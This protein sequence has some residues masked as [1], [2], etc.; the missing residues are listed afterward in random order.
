MLNKFVKL[1]IFK[2][3][4]VYIIAMIRMIQSSNSSHAKSYF[5]DSLQKAD[6]YISDQ[7]QELQGR[8]HGK[9]SERIGLDPVATKDSFFAFCENVNP[10]TGEPLTARTRDDRTIGYDINFHCPKSVSILHVLSKDNHIM[11]AFQKS[12]HETMKHIEADSMTRVRK[13]GTQE[14]RKTGELVYAEFTHQ[15]ARPVEGFAPDPHLHSHCFTFNA[16]WDEEEKQIKAC[17]FRDI[18]RDMPY[19]Q[20]RFHKILS[21][22]LIDLGYEIRR[23][24]KSFEVKGI[25]KGVIGLFS[26][27]TDEIGQLAKEHG[28]T[29]PKQLDELGARTRSSKQKGLSM[30]ELKTEWRRQINELAEY[31]DGEQDGI[32]R[33][34]PEKLVSNIAVKDCVDHAVK[35][36]F[37]RASVMR[38]RRI[39]ETAYRHS[40]GARNIGLNDITDKFLADDEIIHVQE[41]HQTLCTTK[42]VLKEE[43]HMVD[44]ARQGKGKFN[45]IYANEPEI[46]LDGQLKNAAIHVLT[47]KDQVT[48]VKGGAGTGKTTL[49]NEIVPLLKK[50][51]MAPIIVAPSANASRGVL[52]EEGH[53]NA[54]TVSKLLVDKK[55]QEALKN[56]TLIVDEAGLL[57][58]KQATALLRLAIEKNARLIFLGDTRQHS[59]VER[60]DALRIINTVGGIQT[61]EVSKIHRQKKAE[62]KAAVQDL[63]EGNVKGAF[64][65]LNNIGA[66]KTI[67]PLKPNTELVDD[68]IKTVKK[69]KTA[70]IVSPTNKQGQA[71]TEDVRLRL[72]AER[73]IGKKELKALKLT[74]A[75]FTDAEKT[76][77]RNFEKG[78]IVKFDQNV[79]LIK[80]GSTW[81]VKDVNDKGVIL[82]DGNDNDRALPLNRATAFNVYKPSEIGLSK[83][84]KVRVNKNGFD[85][86]DKRMDNGMAF[87]VQSVTKSGKI[88]LINPKSK[89]VFSIDKDFG[90]IDHDYCTTSHSS[91]GKTVDEV[92]ISQPASTFTAT[93]SKQ[94]YVS[95]SRGRNAVNIYTDDKIALLDNAS[96]IGD[97]KSAIELVGKYDRHKDHVIQKQQEKYRNHEKPTKEREINNRT[98]RDYE[99]EF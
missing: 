46:K 76:D 11:E 24:D 12:V 53:E 31:E 84:D 95:V 14:D 7:S 72:R 1:N 13:N 81:A 34:A 40:I 65:R 97:R 89:A 79:P 36:S 85:D 73:L 91:Q 10:V 58:T 44:L 80:R 16:T 9:L 87:E 57:G 23:T 38:D 51:D 70:L 96:E 61:A 78:Q 62:Y 30:D 3:Y 74:N 6:Y 20:A 99:P 42:A 2:N 90:H 60:G 75:N 32:I 56:K 22:N 64:D 66:I 39:L 17:Q 86:Q 19:Y 4:A 49:L 28:I 21:D 37:E 27:R 33:N 98:D 29:D 71:V 83:G 35:H 5:S 67:D 45:P 77:W 94:F 47:T 54:D 43:K 15:T 25:P 26:K 69:G 59:S 82:T 88:K 63:A 8:Y 41:R 52:V 68:Y 93:D 18:K 48:I 55:M 50:A 92:F